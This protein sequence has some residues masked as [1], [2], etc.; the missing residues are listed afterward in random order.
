M[1]TLNH[2]EIEGEVY[3]SDLSKK[4][5]P[6]DVH[7]RESLVVAEYYEQLG[8][9]NYP[10]RI[11]ECSKY[12]DF[13]VRTLQDDKP[14]FK[15]NAARFCRVR[16]CPICQWRKELM[17]RARFFKHIPRILTDHPK[18]RFVFLT[19]TVKN[20]SL[21]ELRETIRSMNKGWTRLSQRKKFPALG[22]V[23]SLEVTKGNDGTAHPHF[24]IMMMVKPSYFTHGYIKQS[25]WTT[26]WKESMRLDYQPIV[27]IK[28]VKNLKKSTNKDNLQ[29]LGAGIC[30]TLKYS[31]KPTD[32]MSDPQWL[33]GLTTQMHKLRTISLGGIFKSYMSEDDPEDLINSELDDNEELLENHPQYLLY[34]EWNNYIKRY[35]AKTNK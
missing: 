8:Y 29:G 30:E 22:F 6:W 26:L 25:E 17:W 5:K 20:C 33:D 11:R 21:E 4:D 18:A 13:V 35:Q 14:D 15:L 3:L 31:V 2:Y 28:T 32:L 1:S 23:R 19:L 27:N 16:Y 24:H 34:V 7:K 12:L 10:K 9:E